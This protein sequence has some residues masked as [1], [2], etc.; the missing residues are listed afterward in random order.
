MNFIEHIQN[1][2]D[3]TLAELPARKQ[4]RIT[5]IGIL[6]GVE[7][8]IVWLAFFL[9]VEQY[10]VAL[11]NMG[12]VAFFLYLFY[13]AKQK[14]FAS[15]IALLMV[16][17]VVFSLYMTH[18]LGHDS[19]FY[20]FLL[21]LF[22]LPYFLRKPNYLL[23][24]TISIVGA[25]AY[26]MAVLNPEH[27]SHAPVVL[28]SVYI[29]LIGM[30]NMLQTF[31]L[32]ILII[33]ADSYY[34]Y[35]ADK[36]LLLQQTYSDFLLEKILPKYIIEKIKQG[37]REIVSEV[38]IA[39]IAFLD[40]VGFTALSAE[41]TPKEILELLNAF[42]SLCDELALKYKIEKIKT[43]GD[44]YMVAGGVSGEDIQG[45]EPIRTVE[46][47]LEMI[48]SV[49]KHSKSPDCCNINVRIGIN[50]GPVM[51][52]IIGQQRLA[53]DL[54]GHTVNVASRIESSSLTN[55]VAIS[56]STY[57]LVKHKFEIEE[58][59]EINL[60]GLG[61]SRMYVLKNKSFS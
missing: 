43:I 16:Q 41:K 55:H 4:A 13:L 42:F 56:Q 30:A 10:F 52:G 58:V 18:L 14:Q 9:F 8:H 2:N 33:Y 22:T 59:R 61:G 28:E 26:V 23:H 20:Y 49:S 3:D 54:W 32:I 6:G 38:P 60:K 50:S 7:S 27:F 51:A 46:F 36:Q 48:D 24:G 34:T 29:N 37:D 17:V 31:S 57:E 11:V 19:K 44:S 15:A 5:Q 45:D 35:E 21:L 1:F 25:L 53:F 40:I 39:S 12:C 47:A